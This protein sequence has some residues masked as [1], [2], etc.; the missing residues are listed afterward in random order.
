[1]KKWKRPLSSPPVWTICSFDPCPCISL[2]YQPGGDSLPPSPLLD[3]FLFFPSLPLFSF[4]LSCTH[5]S[6]FLRKRTWEINFLRFGEMIPSTKH[7]RY[8]S[9]A[10]CWSPV[11]LLRS[12]VPHRFLI[13]SRWPAFNVSSLKAFKIISLF[14]EFISFSKMWSIIRIKGLMLLLWVILLNYF[15]SNFSL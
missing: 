8:Y 11:L 4:T 5:S 2:P 6:G 14:S 9:I 1:M 3:P 15:F 13:F 12:L 7:W 10:P